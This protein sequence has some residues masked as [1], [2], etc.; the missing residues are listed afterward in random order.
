[1]MLFRIDIEKAEVDP[2]PNCVRLFIYPSIKGYRCGRP[3]NHE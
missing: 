2:V 1:M 3:L